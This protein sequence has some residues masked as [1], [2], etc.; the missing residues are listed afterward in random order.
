MVVLILSVLTGT[1]I[2]LQATLF[3]QSRLN[4]QT[5]QQFRE[6]LFYKNESI[7]QK[8]GSLPQNHTLVSNFKIETKQNNIKSTVFITSTI[9]NDVNSN[10]SIDIG[11]VKI[12]FVFNN[13]NIV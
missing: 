9:Q 5:E 1:A 2:L 7:Y 3:N 12:N 6:F 11:G 8:N 13:E 4:N 10:I